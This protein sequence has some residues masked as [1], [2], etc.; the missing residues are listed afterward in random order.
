MNSSEKKV[1]LGTIVI[2]IVAIIAIV[3]IKLSGAKGTTE[4]LVSEDGGNTISDKKESKRVFKREDF[5]VSESDFVF[6]ASTGTITDYV[7]DETEVFIPPT[8][9]GVEVIT[10]GYAAFLG[11]RLVKIIIP[12]TVTE[13][14]SLAFYNNQISSIDIPNT[15]TTIGEQAFAYNQLTNIDIPNSVTTMG[16]NAFENNKLKDKQAFIYERNED[17]TENKAVLVSYGGSNIDN[18]KIPDGVTIIGNGVFSNRDMTN[19]TIPDG[20][21][22][23]GDYAFSENHLANIIIP[24]SVTTI[25]FAAFYNNPLTS[26]I[27][28][29]SVTNLDFEAFSDNVKIIR[30]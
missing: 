22:T 13:I 26:V 17:G 24:D 3:G 10:I 2:V 23:I 20:V 11:S 28:P 5:N 15:V 18:I 19:L 6:D 16:A 21:T 8:I 27:I 4:T 1:V 29:S 14:G 25:G 7:G 9:G 30:Q 12:N